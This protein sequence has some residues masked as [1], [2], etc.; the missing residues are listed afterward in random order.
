[1]GTYIPS[2]WINNQIPAINATNLN[3]IEGGVDSAHSELNDIVS[4]ATAV[5]K[6]TNAEHAVTVDTATQTTVGGAKIWVDTT[7]PLNIIGHIDAR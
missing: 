7:D 4:G 5:G 6:A 1:M 2:T 3:N